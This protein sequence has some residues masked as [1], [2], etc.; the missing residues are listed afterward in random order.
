MRTFKGAPLYLA[1]IVLLAVCSACTLP[2]VGPESP[3]EVYEVVGQV[4][5]V[6]DTTQL[7]VDTLHIG[8]G[9]FARQEYVNDEGETVRGPT[10]G[11]WILVDG[12]PQQTAR[13]HV[14]QVLIVEGYRIQVVDIDSD[15]WGAY[16]ELDIL[17][18]DEEGDSP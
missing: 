15:N 13:G 12:A 6:Y 5:S 7:H 9:N 8:V 3:T 17:Q 10:V 4:Y 16:V 14:G 18:L 2:E 11:L 1:G